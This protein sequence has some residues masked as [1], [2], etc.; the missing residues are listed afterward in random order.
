MTGT[1]RL[2]Q[3]LLRSPWSWTFLLHRVGS[4]AGSLPPRSFRV[5]CCDDILHY[6]V[7][8][9]P[10]LFGVWFVLGRKKTTRRWL[11]IDGWH[12]VANG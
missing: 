1:H 10:S 9:M 5:C 8:K 3:L 6:T 12:L 11:A 2:V 4:E 7:Y